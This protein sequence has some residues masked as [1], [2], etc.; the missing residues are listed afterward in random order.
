MPFPTKGHSF[1]TTIFFFFSLSN[2][3]NSAP[4]APRLFFSSPQTWAWQVG[5][6]GCCC[7]CLPLVSLVFGLGLG[8]W[9]SGKPEF[10]REAHSLQI[11]GLLVLGPFRHPFFWAN[12]DRGFIWG[13]QGD[14]ELC[15]RGTSHPPHLHSRSLRP[16]GSAEGFSV[17]L[18]HVALAQAAV[19]ERTRARTRHPP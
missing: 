14:S 19:R 17:R 18:H 10:S 2:D 7:G 4:V 15:S 9:A 8:F 16:F 13:F 12:I 5:E 1:Q 11:L 3:H 6:A